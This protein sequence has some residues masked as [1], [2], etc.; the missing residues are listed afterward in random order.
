MDV[1]PLELPSPNPP[2]WAR[3][4]TPLARLTRRERQVLGLVCQY[5]TDA[6]IADILCISRRTASTH[7]SNILGK[8]GAANRREARVTAV[9]FGL[10]SAFP[11][12][13]P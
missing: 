5:L 4:G 1:A 2:W 6:E 9:Q 8:L 12:S 10:H 11:M 13:S 7:V 3:P